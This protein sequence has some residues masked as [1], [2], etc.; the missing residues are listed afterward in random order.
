M[1]QYDVTSFQELLVKHVLWFRG[2]R[3]PAPSLFCFHRLLTCPC[4]CIQRVL[5]DVFVPTFC[6]L[7]TARR[8]SFRLFDFPF[9]GHSFHFFKLVH[10]CVPFFAFMCLLDGFF[11][12]SCFLYAYS[13]F[14]YQLS[15]AFF[16]YYVKECEGVLIPPKKKKPLF[17]FFLL[18]CQY[19]S[20]PVGELWASGSY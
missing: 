12:L 19:L 7:S 4:H 15:L 5:S 10:K 16:K 9:F 2:I 6:F 13:S 11:A 8:C 14:F 3:T 17:F 20:S 1:C 18:L